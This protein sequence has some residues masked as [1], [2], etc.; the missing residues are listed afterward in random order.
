MAEIDRS[1][2]RSALESAT[3]YVLGVAVAIAAGLGLH[4]VDPNIFIDTSNLA[5][6]VLGDA[7]N[8]ISAVGGRVFGMAVDAVSNLNGINVVVPGIK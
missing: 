6:N 3:P 1:P 8:L 4:H 7:S 5:A 2:E